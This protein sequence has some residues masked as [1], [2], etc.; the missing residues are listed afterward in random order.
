MVPVV[1]GSLQLETFSQIQLA[2]AMNHKIIDFSSNQRA[3]KRLPNALIIGARK[4][5]TG[6]LRDMLHI[7]P[8]VQ[9]VRWE[10][11]FFDDKFQRI[12]V[13]SPDHAFGP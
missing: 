10:V 6:A 7:H 5:G 2:V 11:H 12:R 13:V 9:I 3:E 4:C 1:Y 8:D